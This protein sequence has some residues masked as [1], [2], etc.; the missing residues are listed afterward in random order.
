MP[1]FWIRAFSLGLI[2][3]WKVFLTLISGEKMATNIIFM[4][5][6]YFLDNYYRESSLQKNL[7]KPIVVGRMG[8]NYYKKFD[9]EMRQ[10]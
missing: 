3:L 10:H 9:S 6:N 7:T 5:E 1:K 8:G 2:F 4:L